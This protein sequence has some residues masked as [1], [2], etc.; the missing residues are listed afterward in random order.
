MDENTIIIPGHGRP[1]NKKKL[2]RYIAL[3]EHIKDGVATAITSGKS[4]EMVKTSS[5]IS[6]EYDDKYGTGFINPE[7]LRNTF[8]S[9]LKK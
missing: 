2:T 3:L 7:R 9:S 4:L 1:S 8:Y 5:T 6:N